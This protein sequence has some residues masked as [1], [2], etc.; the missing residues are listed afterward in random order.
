[1]PPVIGLTSRTMPLPATKKQ[2]PT[3]T[4]TRTYVEALEAA[5]ALCLMLPNVDPGSAGAYLDRVDG[6]LLTGGD[7]PDPILFGEEPHPNIDVVDARRDRFE[8]A[9]AREAHERGMPLFGICRGVQLF[10]IALGGDIYQDIGSQ[11]ESVIQHTQRRLDDGP[12]HEISIEE[13]SRLHAVVEATSL[14]VNSFHHQ[15]CRRPGRGL[16]VC[17]TSADGLPEAIEDPGRDFYLGVQWHPELG[18]AGSEALFAAFVA[19]ARNSA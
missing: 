9:I 8:I 4:V 7:D 6:V 10:N 16:S 12:W 17:A 18:G 11:T 1:M 19:A 13:G 14:R 15:A 5:G 2:R 3:E